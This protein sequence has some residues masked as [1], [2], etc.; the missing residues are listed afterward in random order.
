MAEYGCEIEVESA[1]PARTLRDLLAING[2]ML[3]A[4]LGVGVLAEPTGLIASSLD[5]LADAGAS[6]GVVSYRRERR[7]LASAKRSASRCVYRRPLRG[8]RRGLP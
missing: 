2:G 5:M 8:L 4:E 1:A 3:V 7:A 6:G